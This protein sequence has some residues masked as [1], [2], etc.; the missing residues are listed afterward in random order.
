MSPSQ[1]YTTF[2]VSFSI[3]VCTLCALAFNFHQF[4]ISFRISLSSFRQ[5]PEIIL[6]YFSYGYKFF[7][8]CKHTY[9]LC[10]LFFVLHSSS[11]LIF[12]S[13]SSILSSSI[14]LSPSS[15]DKISPRSSIFVYKM[16]GMNQWLKHEAKKT[17]TI[18]HKHI[19]RDRKNRNMSAGERSHRAENIPNV[20]ISCFCTF[21]FCPLFHC[22]SVWASRPWFSYFSVLLV[23][24]FKIHLFWF[25][26]VSFAFYSFSIFFRMKWN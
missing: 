17:Q 6:L 10:S 18:R 8:R 4:L 16:H 9:S 1:S 2:S 15:N 20:Q 24:H 25:A 5:P 19:Q 3:S 7:L 12:I 21:V 23:L 13:V 22:V 26:C 14:Y 11:S